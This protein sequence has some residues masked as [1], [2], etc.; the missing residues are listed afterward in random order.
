MAATVTYDGDIYAVPYTSNTWFMY[1]DKRV[2]SEDD[3]KSLDTMLEKGKVSFPLS[4]SWYIQAFYEQTD[5]HYL[6]MVL[7]QQQVSILVVTRQQQLLS[8]L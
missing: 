8:I 6:V 4:N 5:V 7:M 2:F 3:V 1:Y